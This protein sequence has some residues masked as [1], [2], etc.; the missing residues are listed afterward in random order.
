[1]QIIN[2]LILFET[3]NRHPAMLRFNEFADGFFLYRQAAT[4]LVQRHLAGFARRQ[5]AQECGATAAFR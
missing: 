2:Q 4:Q 3:E 5:H 1:M